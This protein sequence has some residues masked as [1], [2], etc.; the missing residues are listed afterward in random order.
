MKY[1]LE[2]L[3]IIATDVEL[4]DAIDWTNINISREK[5][6]QIIASQVYETYG[7]ST[8]PNREAIMLAT[9]IKLIVENFV[10][11]LQL[12]TGKYYGKN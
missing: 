12:E 9:I 2:D 11:N 10:L 6:Y 8:D 3:I 7:H 5:I 1:T 4:G